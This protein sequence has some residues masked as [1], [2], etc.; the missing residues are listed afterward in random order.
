MVNGLKLKHKLLLVIWIGVMTLQSCTT[1]PHCSNSIDFISSQDSIPVLEFDI[2]S[3]PMEVRRQMC[4]LYSFD[5]CTKCSLVEFKVPFEIEGKEGFLKVTVDFDSPICENCP[6]P[7]RSRH[8]CSIL[9][10]SKNQ[11]LFE[12]QHVDIDSLQSEIIGYLSKVGSAPIGPRAIDKVNFRIGWAEGVNKEVVYLMLKRIYQAHLHFVEGE[13]EKTGS[14]FCSLSKMELS[15]LKE[16]YPLKI[17]FDLGKQEF[18]IP[19][20]PEG[21]LMTEE[22]EDF[23]EEGGSE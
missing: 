6:V 19:K 2:T 4:E 20:N 5:L 12:G 22:I 21:H 14:N 16:K 15:A 7:M 11:I 3:N 17:E 18:M 9:I 1:K 23:L 8:Y 10:N 13:I